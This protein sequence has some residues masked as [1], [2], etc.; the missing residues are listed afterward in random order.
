MRTCD[1]LERKAGT[2]SQNKWKETYK[3]QEL[4]NTNHKGPIL[5]RNIPTGEYKKRE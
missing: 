3:V 1:N 4:K 2:T 5:Q